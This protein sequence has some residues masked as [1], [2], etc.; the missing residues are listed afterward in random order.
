MS[1]N[2]YGF[3]RSLCIRNSLCVSEARHH[4]NQRQVMIFNHLASKHTCD[5]LDAALEAWARHHHWHHEL[6]TFLLFGAVPTNHCPRL[7]TN[8]HPILQP[9]FC[10]NP[11]HESIPPSATEKTVG[12]FFKMLIKKHSETILFPG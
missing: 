1:H 8:P 2:N 3:P 7:S 10:L 5:C 11:K 6:S 4:A 9:Q 12:N